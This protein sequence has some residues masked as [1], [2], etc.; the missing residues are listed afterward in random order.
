MS[1]PLNA[2]THR[3]GIPVTSGS[4]GGLVSTHPRAMWA[5][6]QEDPSL[7]DRTGPGCVFTPQSRRVRGNSH[8]GPENGHLVEVPGPPPGSAAGRGA[9]RCT[10][11]PGV[12]TS[13]CTP[14]PCS[15]P[16]PWVSPGLHPP[17]ALLPW[18][19]FSLA[20]ASSHPPSCTV[21]LPGEDRCALGS[22]RAWLGAG[23]VCAHSQAEQ[24]RRA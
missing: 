24:K 15:S 18:C 12:P 11:R 1:P 6:L 19:S 7:A 13:R 9:G 21:T 2:A 22:A 4:S 8:G 17:P 16:H 5:S 20:P 14:Q 23:W 10:G 3:L